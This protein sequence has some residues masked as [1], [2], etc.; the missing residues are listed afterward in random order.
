MSLWL[1]SEVWINIRDNTDLIRPNCGMVNGQ[2]EMMTE[3]ID[4][5]IDGWRWGRVGEDYGYANISILL[6]NLVFTN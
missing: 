5:C 1:S 6:L 3:K 2:Y 4:G